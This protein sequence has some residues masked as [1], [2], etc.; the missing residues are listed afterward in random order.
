MT[1]GA[2]TPFFDEIGIT[3]VVWLDD[4]FE[5]KTRPNEVDIA[6]QVATALAA[7]TMIAH[8]KLGDLTR[9]DPAE[10]W[11]RRIRERLSASE[12]DEFLTKIKTPDPVGNPPETTDY[13]PGELEEVVSSLGSTVHRLGLTAWPREKDRLIEEGAGGVFLVDREHRVGGERATVGDD[14]VKE[15]VARCPDEVMVIVLTHSVGPDGTEQ[16]RQSLA[17]ELQV[18][19]ARLAVV[20]KRPADVSLTNGVRAAVRVSLTQLTCRVVTSRIATAMR[21]A[22]D[23]TEAALG[24]LP[25]SAL[26]RAIFENSFIEGASEID[27]VSRILLSRQRTAV[28]AHVVGALDEMHSP[29]ARMRKLR[30]LEKLPDLP[31]ADTS[32]LTRWRRDEVFDLGKTLNAL[33]APLACGDVFTKDGTQKYFILLGQPCDLIVRADG[34]RAIDEAVLVRLATSYNPAGAS[35][36]RFFEV[37][38]LEGTERWAL[39]FRSWVSVNLECLE[40]TCFNNDGRVIFSAGQDVPSGLLPGWEKRF[41]SAKNK[42]QEGR[43]YRLSLGDL[44]SAGATAS[45]TAVEF[46]YRR[47]ARLRA[48]RAVGAYAAFNTFQARAAF[49]HDFAKGIGGEQAKQ[50]AP[51]SPGD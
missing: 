34:H 37:P 22:L 27:V 30:L 12:I 6:Q 45:A 25:V 24:K 15:L 18:P 7:G 23:E 8:E 49:D 33:R 42:F 26:D 21:K 35:E 29:L 9:E 14:I 28:D 2:V 1:V 19:I 11:A 40:W 44:P 5:E 41:E 36:G 3:K 48:P 43:D 4:L 10:E 17:S 47:I 16:L 32:L 38:P 39:D 50:G 51:T 13:S 31:P 20:S 46:P